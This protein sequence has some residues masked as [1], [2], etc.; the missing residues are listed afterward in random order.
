MRRHLPAGGHRCVPP[1]LRAAAIRPR[2][3]R[4]RGLLAIVGPGIVSGFA[5]N[6]AGGITTY[7]IAGAQFGYDLLWVLLVSQLALMV[8]QEAGARLGLAT[9]HGLSGLI[10]ERYGVRWATFAVLTMLAANLGDT[11]AEFAGIGAALALFGVPIALSALAGRRRDGRPARPDEL[12]PDPDPVRRSSAWRSRVAYV[13]SAVLAR[14]DWGQA[15][16]SLVIP[17]GQSRAP[18]TS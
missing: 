16:S 6:D 14:P 9:G 7:S 13:V 17:H 5:D 4:H 8:T 12:S 2:P 1:Y 15:A 11:V 3:P 18:R 10:R